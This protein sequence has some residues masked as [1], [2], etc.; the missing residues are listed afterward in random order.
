[1]TVMMPEASMMPEVDPMAG[2]G[3]PELYLVQA[4]QMPYTMPAMKLKAYSEI[5]VCP[6][7]YVGGFSV[8]CVVST[9]FGVTFRVDGEVFNTEY[10]KPYLL[11]GDKNGKVFPF[12]GLD[13]EHDV[14][15]ACQTG[16]GKAV[17]VDLVRK[18]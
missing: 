3:T 11:N 18:C 8:K 13:E 7:K 9:S 10:R 16:S 6:S 2:M 14:R 1:M 17:W 12:R 15:V 5:K 4:G